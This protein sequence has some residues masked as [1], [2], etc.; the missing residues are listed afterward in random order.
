[1]KINYLLFFLVSNL[2]FSQ[3]PKWKDLFSYSNIKEIEQVDNKLFCS[4][5]GGLFEYDLET[6]ETKKISKVNGLNGVDVT[7]F[8]YNKTNQTFLVAYA[9]GKFDVFSPNGI[10][11]NVDIVIDADFNGDK[12]IKHISSNGNFA[13]LSMDFGILYFDISRKEVK[14]TVYFRAASSYHKAN[15]GVIFNNTIVVA[16]SNGLYY[17]TIDP[18]LPDFSTWSSYNVGANFKNVREFNSTLFAS[19]NDVVFKSTD[20]INWLN[21]SN[22]LQLQNINS[23]ANHLIFTSKNKINVYDKSLNSIENKNFTDELNNGIYTNKT[24][25]AGSKTKGLLVNDEAIFPDGPFKNKSYKINLLDDKIWITSVEFS[26][27]FISDNSHLSFS[28]F[29]GNKWNYQKPETIGNPMNVVEV[30][31]NPSNPNQVFAT[32][33]G[34][35]SA[36]LKIENQTLIKNFNSTNSTISSP[37]HLMGLV[38]DKSGNLFVSERSYLLPN[39]G[40]EHAIHIKNPKDEFV[41]IGLN[42]VNLA[43]ETAISSPI[44]DGKGNLY[45]CGPR[46][47]GVAILDYNNTPFNLSDDKFFV[48]SNDVTKGNLPSNKAICSVFDN[49]G[50][51][52]IG[53]ER[54]LRFLRNPRSE[55]EK[56]IFQTQRIIIEQ[57][58]LGEELLRDVQINAI[59]V[60]KANR[61]WIATDNAGVFYISPNGDK[62]YSIFNVNNSPLPS[63]QIHDVKIDHKNGLVYFTTSLGTVAYMSDVADAPSD[64]DKVV[65]YPNPVRPNFNQD[66]IIKN[67]PNN[68]FVKIT[69][70][71]GNLIYDEKASGGIVQWNGRNLKGN[72][73]ASGIYLVLMTNSDGSKHGST[74]IAVVR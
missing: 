62:T 30:I 63:N 74:K 13:V 50:T 42:K 2:L 16:S 64:F 9:D 51:L 59:A 53:T 38:F 66:I 33:Y 72:E 71:V 8:H 61:K 54:G 56:E 23:T 24:I 68:S 7:A 4:T 3:Y 12:S 45:V 15:K 1:M 29:D 18:S 60:D 67:I 47:D 41:K 58:G 20:A 14:E 48:I 70:L 6:N 73:V 69:D 19:S 55:V 57:S 49:S 43:P 25:F 17:K 46:G 44:L 11:L 31:P 65:V 52:W 5:E 21:F 40:V 34:G 36:L 10:R 35:E 32:N 39:D 22:F 28:Y 26:D 27:F 37:H